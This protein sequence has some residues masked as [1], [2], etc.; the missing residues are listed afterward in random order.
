MAL[1]FSASIS[2]FCALALASSN[3]GTC[4]NSKDPLVLGSSPLLFLSSLTLIDSTKSEILSISSLLP[5]FKLTV[6][7]PVLLRAKSLPLIAA[8]FIAGVYKVES[9]GDY[10]T[11]DPPLD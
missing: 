10:T 2:A 7:S 1:Y 8:L 3:P 6:R 5:F 9:D 11:G 4:S